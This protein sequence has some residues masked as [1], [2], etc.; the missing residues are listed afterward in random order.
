[1]KT[2][3]QSQEDTLPSG[4]Q[5][6]Q[7]VECSREIARN[8]R[9]NILLLH[10]CQSQANVISIYTTRGLLHC[11]QFNPR[12][13]ERADKSIDCEDMGINMPTMMLIEPSA[14]W[15]RTSPLEH[16]AAYLLALHI[17]YVYVRNVLVGVVPSQANRQLSVLC[18]DLNKGT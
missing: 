4:L 2:E 6:D 8:L 10:W 13:S 16:D 17:Y 12:A 7:V 3:S 15:T 11:R 1:M 9:A 14:S 18:L 5:F